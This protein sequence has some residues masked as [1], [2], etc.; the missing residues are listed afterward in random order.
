MRNAGQYIPRIG[1]RG[2]VARGGVLCLAV[3]LLLAGCLKMP[4]SS[5]EYHYALTGLE[6]DADLQE[7]LQKI[8]DDQ[9]QDESDTED[10]EEAQR[11]E[12]YNERIVRRN[13]VKALQARGYYDAVVEY[14]DADMTRAG[15][16][17][18]DK[19]EIYS[20][21]AVRIEPG[22]FQ[23]HHE[24]I[25]VKVGDVVLAEDVLVSQAALY[26][27]IQ[28]E[29][30]FYNLKVNH[31]AILD[32]ATKKIEIVF[33]V[34]A[35]PEAKLGELK[36]K[37]LTSVQE[38][39]LRNF[40][41]WKKGDCFRQDR[42]ESLRTT[43]L[44]SSLFS[45]AEAILPEEPDE[46]GI[47]N[48]TIEVKERAHRTVRAGATYY[49]DEGPGIQL[50]WEHRNMFG[51][52]EKLSARLKASSLEQSLNFDLS[53]PF[54]FTKKQ[55]LGFTS[56]IRRKDTDAFEELA[57]GAGVNL[58]HRF[59][60]HLSGNTGA[61]LVFSRITE[62]NGSSENYAT[63]SFPNWLTYDNRKD[64]LL[65]PHSGWYARVG[66]EPFYDMLGNGDPFIKA[67]AMASTYISLDEDNDTILALR[68]GVGSITGVFTRAAVV[69]YVASGIRKSARLK[70]ASRSAV[71]V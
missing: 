30:C 22:D 2:V 41:S 60:R 14:T 13:M 18:V 27:E 1:G 54:F 63:I 33:K 40:S 44:N 66:I 55:T 56:T 17:A 35:G 68:A 67:Q 42:I 21:S 8:V 11:Q 31:V 15:T 10:E 52:A 37:G 50:G 25:T 20:I 43:L 23:K 19:G 7:R 46:N 59:N 53:K 48:V 5:P 69:R 39:Y 70:M 36:Y 65:N 32:K 16:Y 12:I 61:D 47:V 51:E 64:D 38:P 28:K 29:N 34:D 4:F 6:D 9:F 57:V 71:V 24:A 62:E 58:S 26:Q 3:T 49:T 45:R